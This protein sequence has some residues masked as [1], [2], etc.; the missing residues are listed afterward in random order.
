[1]TE[2]DWL[3][4][5]DPL[6]MLEYVRRNVSDRK[7]RL[8]SVACCR[9]VWPLLEQIGRQTVEFTEQYADGQATA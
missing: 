7:L 6:P 4:C 9:L 2:A 1:M 5:G 3:A 8:F